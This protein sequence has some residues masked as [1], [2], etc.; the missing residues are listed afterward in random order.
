MA[1]NKAAVIERPNE[2]GYNVIAPA[3]ADS[4]KV[5]QCRLSQITAEEVRCHL[6]GLDHPRLGIPTTLYTRSH[7]KTP[8]TIGYGNQTKFPRLAKHPLAKILSIPAGKTTS[9]N[10]ICLIVVFDFDFH[11]TPE[12]EENSLEND[13]DVLVNWFM[14]KYMPS[15]V[16]V[17]PSTG[18]AGRHA[19]VRLAVPLDAHLG[20]VKAML[21][22]FVKS[23]NADPEKPVTIAKLDP[24]VCNFPSI[25]TFE[26]GKVVAVDRGQCMKHPLWGGRHLPVW[27]RLRNLVR[28]NNSPVFLLRHF[29]SQTVELPQHH[30]T[31][32][33]TPNR[34]VP[35]TEGKKPELKPPRRDSFDYE[36]ELEAVR[37][38]EC[39]PLFRTR[40]FYRLQNRRF[41]RVLTPEEIDELYVSLGL[42][43]TTKHERR[44]D[45]W[46]GQYP[47]HVKQFKPSLGKL[48]PAPYIEGGFHGIIQSRIP[49]DLMT[50]KK[51]K[52][53]R[54]ISHMKIRLNDLDLHLSLGF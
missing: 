6:Y 25:L 13:V 49:S 5:G 47:V 21:S 2:K 43:R 8:F 50:Y 10:F 33:P 22:A 26:Y 11:L 19:Y 42:N 52:G 44:K 28:F 23:V 31:A 51:N 18:G 29:K 39:D 24:L 17:E 53:N 35:P 4:K 34:Y 30:G 16:Y 3:E 48:I 38:E 54:R 27:K 45:L 41:N 32:T 36:A 15:G 1:Q 7:H 40:M 37:R 20:H 12:Q 46:R 14:R 9:D